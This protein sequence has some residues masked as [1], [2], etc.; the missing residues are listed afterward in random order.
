M[1]GVG[2]LLSAH[3]L[4]L[5]L[6]LAL[7][8]GAFGE[9]VAV[10]V[11]V[12]PEGCGSVILTPPDPEPGV[13]VNATAIHEPGCRFVMW[14]SNVREI[15]GSISN[16]LYFYARPNM[17]LIAV[18]LRLGEVE[19]NASNYAFLVVKAN[20]SGF[21]EDVRLVPRGFETFISAPNEIYISEDKRWVFVGWSGD[22][23][24]ITGARNSPITSVRVDRDVTLVASY[25][26]YRKFLNLWYPESEFVNVEAPVRE[27]SEGVRA[28]PKLLRMKVVNQT[29]PLTT[30]IPRDLLGYVEVVYEDQ[31]LIRVIAPI[32]EPVKVAV[33]DVIGLSFED[34]PLEYWAPKDSIVT[35]TALE[36]EVGEYWLV[37]EFKKII[38]QATS[39]KTVILRYERKPYAWMSGL[40]FY[41][42]VNDIAIKLR[43]TRLWPIALVIL[44][45]PVKFYITF[46][47]FLGMIGGVC[48][49]GYLGM[50][51][52]VRRIM[53]MARKEKKATREPRILKV[54]Q[55]TLARSTP[56][57]E[58]APTPS[59]EN[60]LVNFL[61]DMARSSISAPVTDTSLPPAEQA[62]EIDFTPLDLVLSGE[63]REVPA[64]L[65]VARRWTPQHFEVLKKAVEEGR[66]TLEGEPEPYQDVV[67]K[68]ING[69]SGGAVCVYGDGAPARRRVV[70][71]V[72]E[73]LGRRPI[74]LEEPPPRELQNALKFLADKIEGEP[75]LVVA[76]EQVPD[77][78][79]KLLTAASG[80][81][82][83]PFVK[84]SKEP[85]M[86]LTNV[87]VRDL[88]VEDLLSTAI[89][90]AIK[91]GVLQYF[92][93]GALEGLANSA[94][95]L[96]GV[97]SLERFFEE[98]D[99]SKSIDEQIKQLIESELKNMFT[100]EELL[101]LLLV[102][103]SNR[104]LSEAV[105]VYKNLL[106]QLE[107][108]AN[109]NDMVALFEDKIKKLVAMGEAFKIPGRR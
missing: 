37:P 67:E 46:G 80:I 68:V 70:Y 12:E 104:P 62:E 58:A 18:F 74:I 59:Y 53:V 40:F 17:T 21:P 86:G 9:E 97:D 16:P 19:A 91:K 99:P 101:S 92:N 13:Y 6:A 45:D 26:L 55:P 106:V 25:I 65:I 100:N 38:I 103:Q 48:Y 1:R 64:K 98:F 35:I 47:G 52:A 109:I 51:R 93:F 63:K 32:D 54:I 105:R 72:A 83:A 31:Y 94:Y 73:A 15:N 75:P 39:P 61:L 81:L 108:K 36:D 14:K 76:T 34:R 49:A 10:K 2:K 60:P 89:A 24:A 3:I 23:D 4:I 27:V 5:C 69:L 44:S 107:P 84:L 102:A 87:E 11:M 77:D 56:S 50:R 29:F 82:D 8:A 20:V 85:V 57:R 30:K 95:T 66:L 33:E 71:K 42:F 22:V 43:D 90:L 78:Y 96:R 88:T 41:P 79:V 7:M 28:V